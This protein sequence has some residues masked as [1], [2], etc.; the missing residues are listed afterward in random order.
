M[1][2]NDP[3]PDAVKKRYLCVSCDTPMPFGYRWNICRQCKEEIRSFNEILKKK[4]AAP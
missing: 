4:E 2:D 1:P 3:E